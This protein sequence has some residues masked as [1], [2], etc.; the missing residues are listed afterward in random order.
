MSVRL[1]FVVCSHLVPIRRPLI[2]D[3]AHFIESGAIL[4][5]IRNALVAVG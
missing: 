5:L 1:P 4:V 3:G 2:I